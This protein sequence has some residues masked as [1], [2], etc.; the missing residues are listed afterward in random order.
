[1]KTSL[2][3][4]ILSS[5]LLQ[6]TS[7]VRFRLIIIDNGFGYVPERLLAKTYK[8]NF[9]ALIFR[10]S[11][12][13]YKKPTSVSKPEITEIPD[14]PE[15]LDFFEDDL[16]W[17]LISSKTKSEN[18]ELISKKTYSRYM[19]PSEYFKVDRDFFGEN[20]NSF[21]ITYEEKIKDFLNDGDFFSRIGLFSE[22]GIGENTG[23]SLVMRNTEFAFYKNV[24]Y[25]EDFERN[26]DFVKIEEFEVKKSG[27]TIFNWEDINVHVRIGEGQSDEGFFDFEDTLDHGLVGAL[28]YLKDEDFTRGIIHKNNEDIIPMVFNDGYL[29]FFIGFK[30]NFEKYKAGNYQV[31]TEKKDFQIFNVDKYTDLKE[32]RYKI[33]VN[34]VKNDPIAN[35]LIYCEIILDG[36]KR[37]FYKTKVFES[38]L[39]SDGESGVFGENPNLDQAANNCF[40]HGLYSEDFSQSN[41]F[42]RKIGDY[43]TCITNISETGVE[44]TLDKDGSKVTVDRLNRIFISLYLFSEKDPNSNRII[45]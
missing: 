29:M 15:F 3:T 10:L 2:K 18:F 9:S 6:I 38:I 21:K 17:E 35:V 30:N 42:K 43:Y 45:I 34:R 7:C 5:I 39:T 37:Y 26:S 25:V 24:Y 27:G 8:K 19:Y 22:K 36:F 11:S 4:L 23:F 40:N 14:Y 31:K 12:P 20:Q 33:N 41:P 44:A 16:N 1:M 28:Y 13:S 32:N